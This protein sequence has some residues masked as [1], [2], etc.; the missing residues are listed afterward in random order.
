MSR[1]AVS[2][3][4]DVF[5]Q[6]RAFRHPRGKRRPLPNELRDLNCDNPPDALDAAQ[7]SA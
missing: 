3:P 5:A 7:L 4:V 1:P 2:S 6:V